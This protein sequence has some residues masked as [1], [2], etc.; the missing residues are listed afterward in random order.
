MNIAIIGIGGVGGYYGGRLAR[1]YEAGDEH[2][3]A[4]VAR[5]A[6]LEAIR[7]QGLRVVTPDGEFV[8]RPAQATDRPGD[9]GPLDLVLITVKGY[10]LDGAAGALAEVT[11]E[12]TVVIPLEN[13]VDTAERL[14]KILPRARVLNGT[15]YISSRIAAPGVVQ[16]LG[17]AGSLFFGPETGPAAPFRTIE[18]LFLEAGIQAVL[19]EAVAVEVWKKFLFISPVAGAT[20][21]F[22]KSLGGILEDPEALRLL[23]GMMNEVDRLARARGIG[24]PASAVAQAME[25]VARF[26]YETKT[27]FQ[28]D[29]ENGRK[30]E[31]E[32]FMG[33]VVRAG[34]ALGIDT[35]FNRRVYDALLAKS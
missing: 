4:F 35:P 8:A 6:H 33:Y 9:L 1:R 12:A 34:Q 16:Q 27:S 13:G 19:T 7:K 28:V 22:G 11:G 3:I 10:D 32:T 25:T 15:V 29:M 17:G 30:T 14:G 20:A 26:P 18:S 23:E 21:L 5:G 2:R 31:I 24:L